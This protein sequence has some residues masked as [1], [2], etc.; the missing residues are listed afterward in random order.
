MKKEEKK[1]PFFKGDI[2]HKT[3][4]HITNMRRMIKL[5]NERAIWEPQTLPS[6]TYSPAHGAMTH[7]YV[8]ITH[9]EY[10]DTCCCLD[11]QSYG[12]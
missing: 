8:N 2:I 1:G 3:Q 10:V 11:V 7:T 9:M 5:R 12:Y 6:S 4:S